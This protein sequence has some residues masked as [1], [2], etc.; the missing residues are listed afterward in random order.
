MHLPKFILNPLFSSVKADEM[1]CLVTPLP[2]AA[3]P[4]QRIKTGPSNIGFQWWSD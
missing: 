1:M 3:S 2:A 4:T